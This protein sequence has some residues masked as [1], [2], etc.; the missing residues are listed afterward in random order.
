MGDFPRRSYPPPVAACADLS[1]ETAPE[2]TV[3]T[4][5]VAPAGDADAWVGGD[6]D[7]RA[8]VIE[9]DEAAL[10]EVRALAGRIRATPLATLLRS[11]DDHPLDAVRAVYARAKAALDGG[12]GIAVIDR[13]PSTRSTTTTRR[14]PSS[15]PSAASSPARS[16]RSGTA[17]CSTT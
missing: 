12:F 14:R 9:L 16:P 6:L 10:D 1:A 11:P 17:R 3:G 2:A 13:L 5:G 8:L 15:G 4:G 7:P